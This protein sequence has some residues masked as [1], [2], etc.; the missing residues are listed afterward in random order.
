MARVTKI[1]F[2]TSDGE[3]KDN[4]DERG[5]HFQGDI[6]LPL[7]PMTKNGLIDESYRWTDGNLIYSIDGNFSE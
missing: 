2:F 5:N 3:R 6:V 4:P 7:H 1:P